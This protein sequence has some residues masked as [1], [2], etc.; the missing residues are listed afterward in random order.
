MKLIENVAMYITPS[1]PVTDT[2][3]RVHWSQMMNQDRCIVVAIVHTL[4][5]CLRFPLSTFCI[6]DVT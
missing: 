6:P 3:S 1:S 2:V 5:R 4:F